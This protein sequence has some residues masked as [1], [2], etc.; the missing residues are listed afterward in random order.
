MPL[1]TRPAAS[2]RRRT[3]SLLLTGLLTG[4]LTGVAVPL[5]GPAAAVACPTPVDPSTVSD[6]TPVNGL[7]VASGT[8]PTPFTGTVLGVVQDGIAPDVDMIIAR[9]SSPELTAAGGVW[10]GMSGSPVYLGTG[11]TSLVGAVSYVLSEGPSMVAGITPATAMYALRPQLTRATRVALPRELQKSLTTNAG[12]SAAAAESGMAQLPVSVA[13]SGLRG[14]HSTRIGA[15]L[16]AAEDGLRVHRAGAARPRQLRASPS[17][18]VPGGNL[19]A[20]LS[21]GDVTIAGIGTTTAVCN[22]I[23]LAFG[24]PFLHLGRT[25]LSTHVASAVYVQ[26]DPA[27][28]PFKVANPGDVVGRVDQDRLA[29]LRAVLDGAIPASTTVRSTVTVDGAAPNRDGLTRV[30]VQRYLPGIAASAL[31][32]DIDRTS[33]RV[34]E[35][36][37]RVSW[38]VTGTT[39][40]GP[41]T[42]SR[43]NRYASLDDVSVEPLSELSDQLQQLETNRFADVDINL[44]DL[45]AALDTTYNDFRL[46]GVDQRQDDG[47]YVRLSGDTPLEIVVGQPVSLRAV[48]ATYRNR[49][50][51]IAYRPLTLTA[52][53]RVADSD[54]ELVLS[55]GAAPDGDEAGACLFDP[56]FCGAVPPEAESFPDLVSALSNA[57]R[58]DQVRA[59][60]TSGGPADPDNP[61]TPVPVA[62]A[63]TTVAGVASGAL[64]VPVTY[65]PPQGSKPALFEDGAFLLRNRLSTGDPNEIV[66][67]GAPGDVPLWGDWDGDGVATPGVRRGAEFLLS[68]S[69]TGDAPLVRFVFGSTTDVGL[70]GDWDGDG[71]TTIGVFRSGTWYL[72]NTNSGGS[73]QTT[74]SFGRAGDVPVPG[75]WNGD[76]STTPAVYRGGTWYLLGPDGATSFAYGAATDRPVAGDWNGDGTDSVGVYREGRWLLRNDNS[77]G[78]TQISFTYGTADVLPVVWR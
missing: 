8:T 23:A 47:S 41:F 7:T 69:P 30:N 5:A 17:E 63:T 11:D 12:V 52:P 49:A 50:P 67:F 25:S 57:P 29:G 1:P 53:S 48:L 77:A 72:R 10:S 40:A 31:L 45:D 42:L 54:G 13:M 21:Y 3:T 32:A 9:L 64:A 60:L 19:A 43:T 18:I 27:G 33:D 75:D 34:G 56:T 59:A 2:R 37:L 26:E 66:P 62:S 6:S 74:I 4:A 73:A 36:A 76:G 78:T 55:A 51:G 71:I 68:N 24:H 46:V 14:A 38:S 58:N 20:A 35:G 39:D 28:T 22:G 65:L 61:G 70:A 15:A 16:S 44:V